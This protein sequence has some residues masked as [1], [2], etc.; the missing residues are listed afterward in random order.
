[1]STNSDTIRA[2]ADEHERRAREVEA[3]IKKADEKVDLGRERA[4][5]E[6]GGEHLDKLLTALDVMGRRLDDAFKRMDD[7]EKA[8]RDDDDAKKRDDAKKA[9]KK[10]DDDDDDD[11][12]EK[13]E[14]PGEAKE[15]VADSNPEHRA[16]FAEAQQ[17][18]DECA[19]A[20]GARAPAPLFQEGLRSFRIRILRP[21]LRHSKQFAQASLESI[22][23]PAVFDSVER[24]VYADGIAASYA[25]DSVPRGQLRMITKRLPS[26]HTINEFVGEPQAWMDRF[27]ANRRYVTRVNTKWSPPE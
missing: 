8:K 16:L 24:S 23:D 2:D 15:V 27:A 1:M 17:R 22:T 19:Q 6:N 12:M 4:P 11:D 5:G 26:G 14:S 25:P 10:R 9:K 7:M 21:W 20:W 3:M 13:G 18:C